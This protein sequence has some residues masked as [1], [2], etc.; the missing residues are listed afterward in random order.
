MSAGFL[1]NCEIS[2]DSTCA[3]QKF[4]KRP[5]LGMHDFAHSEVPAEKFFC[6]NGSDSEMTKNDGG[7]CLRTSDGV[8]GGDPSP[9]SF[10]WNAPASKN[11]KGEY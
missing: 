11:K 8:V 5:K 10:A 2:V 7:I 6:K 1:V 3:L 4:L 9:S